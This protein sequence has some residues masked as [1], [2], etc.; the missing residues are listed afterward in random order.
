VQVTSVAVQGGTFS[1]P[2]LPIFLGT[3]DAQD[4]ALLD[5]VIN[6]P[7]ADGAT[8]Y[9]L[10]VS[11]TYTYNGGLY[12]FSVNRAVF[13]NAAGPAPV[14]GTNGTS[15]IF[16]P[17]LV[18]YPPSPPAPPFLPNAETPIFVPIG[19]PAPGSPP[20]SSMGSMNGT[21]AAGSPLQIPINNGR[22]I[23]AGTPPDPNAAASGGD[24]VLSTYNTGISYSTMNGQAGTFTDINLT[25]AV[26]GEP[27]RTSFFPQSDMG[28]CCDQVVVYLPTQNLFVWLMQYWPVTAC[29]TNCP[30]QPPPA[31]AATFKITQPNRL[32][33][34]WATPQTISSN[35][36]DAWTYIDLTANNAPGVS[37]GLGAANN[38][39]VDYPDLA[40]SSTFLYVGVDHGTT[41]PGSIYTQQRIVARVSLADM[42]NP[43]T[44]TVGYQYARLTGNGLSKTHIVQNA[45]GRMVVGGLKD[46]S[47]LNMFVWDDNGNMI[48]PSTVGLDNQIQQG[49]SYTSTAPDGIDWLA[50]SFPGNITGATYRLQFVFGGPSQDQ[51]IFA[52]DAGMNP[53]GRPRSYVRLETLT[54]SGAGWSVVDEYDIWNTDYAFAMAGLGTDNNN[55]IGINLAVGGGTVGYPQ[56]SVGFKDDFIVFQVTSSNATQSFLN[57]VPPGVINPTCATVGCGARFGDY[58]SARYIASSDSQFA[59]EAYDVTLPAGS[60]VGSTCVTVGCTANPRYVQFGRPPVTPPK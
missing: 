49:M 24:V 14:S 18:A 20:I 21:A 31:P 30:P 47:T 39:W 32:R 41:T 58:L 57:P 2:L 23:G 38:E 5:F 4:S 40:W 17:R 12:G 46:S 9:L 27:G 22:S 55:E 42:T 59:A 6:V 37:S 53:P 15:T 44:N 51:Y 52:F 50:A 8:R 16:N 13:P 54:P 45:P 28:I 35:F 60:P 43:N 34:A 11:G 26:P 48:N 10:T 25:A 36:Y 1:G 29:A 19:P 3:V 7:V 56:E 33:V